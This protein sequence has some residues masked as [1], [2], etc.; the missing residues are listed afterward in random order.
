MI[1]IYITSWLRPDFLS[2]TIDL[3]TERTTP[4]SYQLHVFDNASDEET[5]GLLLSYF[6]SGLI[7][8]LHLDSRNTG[9]L[10]NKAVFHAMTESTSEYYVVTD[11]DVYPP[12]IDPDWLSQLI[13]IMDAH[14]DLAF[15]APQL[16]P[17]FLQTP[18]NEP[19]GDIR[20]CEAVGNTLKVCRREAY[21]FGEY[22]Q[23]VGKYGD[24]GKV[25]ELVRKKGW[26]VAFARKVYCYHAGQCINWG[27]KH[28]EIDKDP[29]KSG[30]GKPFEY[31]VEDELTFIPKDPSW[32]L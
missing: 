10:Y 32:R 25:C 16:P 29:R 1:D 9:C 5:K 30:Y 31:E 6:N 2:K 19:S 13:D 12:K 18:S 24:D 3:L 28:N 27:Y 23:L 20:Y 8:S 14:P 21:P 7:K 17:Q 15:L 11:N 26:K 22:E 4:N